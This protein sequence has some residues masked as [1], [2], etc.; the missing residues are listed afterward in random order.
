MIQ[1]SPLIFN[2][3]AYSAATNKYFDEHSFSQVLLEQEVGEKSFSSPLAILAYN[4]LALKNIDAA[5]INELLLGIEKRIPEDV[6]LEIKTLVSHLWLYGYEY[7][8]SAA[9]KIFMQG[10]ANFSSGTLGL[11]DLANFMFVMDKDIKNLELI[12]KRL[13][14]L[15]IKEAKTYDSLLITFNILDRYHNKS[16]YITST[17]FLLNHFKE[18]ELSNNIG[19]CY[20]DAIFRAIISY[21]YNHYNSLY[22][23][24]N[25]SINSTSGFNTDNANRIKNVL[26]GEYISSVS[27]YINTFGPPSL[28]KSYKNDSVSELIRIL[29]SMLQRFQLLLESELSTELWPEYNSLPL[30]WIEGIV[31]KS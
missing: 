25:R 1:I 20:D 11:V 14:V 6:P 19:D 22:Y 7:E 18:H 23:Y 13:G 15:R 9:T 8:A 17:Y 3:E 28:M 30:P 24:I 4:K 10:R 31:E 16:E 5:R 29:D 12:D 2:I 21:T 27:E 26:S